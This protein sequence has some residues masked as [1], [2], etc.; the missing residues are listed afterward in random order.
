[1]FFTFRQYYKRHRESH[2]RSLD[3][4]IGCDQCEKSFHGK[5][6][7]ARHKKT[8]HIHN[9]VQCP[10]CG[11]LFGNMVR[12]KGHMVRHRDKSVSCS[13]CPVKFWL[14]KEMKEHVRTVHRKE[15]KFVCELCGKGYLMNAQLKK[16]KLKGTCVG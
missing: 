1:M 13:E 9:D 8:V 4:L 5:I 15:R 16:H 6:R 14:T 3:N 12:L 11:K 2:N 10:Q 7:L